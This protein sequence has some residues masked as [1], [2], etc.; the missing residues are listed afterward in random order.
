[1]SDTADIVVV[2]GGC[3]GT[4]IA[5]QL[6]RR[7]AG[8]IILID[9]LGVAGGATAR[10]SGYVRMHY[11]HEGPTRMAF[12]ALSV[13]Q[14]F[15]ERV[16]SDAGFRN[17]GCMVLVSERDLEAVQ[18][19]VAMHR[20]IGVNARVINRDE[21][22]EIVPQLDLEGVGAAAWE[23]DSGFADPVMTTNGYADAAREL[24][25]EIR[26]GPVITSIGTS[27]GGVTRIETSAGPIEA[28][29]VLV[30][31]GF[32]TRELILP[33]GLDLEMTPVRHAE[34]LIERTPDFGKVHPIVMDHV[35]G[36][37]YRPDRGDLTLMGPPLGSDEPIDPD[38]EADKGPSAAIDAQMV[39]QFIRR[40][41]SQENA[42][43]RRS[44][45]GIFD[46][47]PD[48]QPYLGAVPGVKGLFVACGF[49]GHGFKL[50]PAIG[51]AM[52]D[53]VIG[54]K[55]PIVDLNLFRPT[56]LVEGDPVVPAY[57]YSRPTLG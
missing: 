21:I 56:R 53:C 8:K 7:K 11:V 35:N 13:F 28:G 14:N 3:T 55:S 41:P 17:S 23:P 27:G 37:S 57:P 54:V 9:K 45:T 50:S 43:M 19:N 22:K 49:S 40:F 6:A 4:S 38:V 52:A 48:M 1:M 24:G 46:C 33:F 32:R 16:G 44:Y 29:T 12:H 39:E 5:W 31:A 36:G 2:G 25:V 10:S 30:A 34:A 42:V 26:I 15:K 51:E 47:T 18:A 20:A